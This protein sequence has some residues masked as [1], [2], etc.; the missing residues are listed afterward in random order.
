MTQTMQ[1]VIERLSRLPDAKQERM[2]ARIL[3]QLEA[4]EEGASWIADRQWIG[5]RKPTREEVIRAIDGMRELRKGITLGNDL[6][7][8]DLI[9]E[10]R[11]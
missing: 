8:R 10:G 7:I 4:E 9:N 2:A 1:R 6:T 5:G 3:K 11:R